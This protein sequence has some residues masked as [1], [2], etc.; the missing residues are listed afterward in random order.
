VIEKKKTMTIFWNECATGACGV[1]AWQS[2]LM[3]EKTLGEATS[4][5]VFDLGLRGQPLEGVD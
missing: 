3:K 2:G 5:F 1:I 4:P